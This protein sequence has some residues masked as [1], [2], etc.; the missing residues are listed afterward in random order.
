MSKKYPQR[1]IF[2]LFPAECDH[3]LQ[4]HFTLAFVASQSLKKPDGFFFLIV[5]AAKLFQAF[6]TDTLKHENR[7]LVVILSFVAL[8][9]LHK[10]TKTDNGDFVRP[11]RY[12]DDPFT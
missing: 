1:E 8:Y 11:L 9:Y 10:V 5:L 4:Q 6:L 2:I 3:L 7:T 12:M